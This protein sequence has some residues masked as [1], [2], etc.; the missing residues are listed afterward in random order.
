MFYFSSPMQDERASTK[1][2]DEI[3]LGQKIIYS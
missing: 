1:L 3:N 2:F